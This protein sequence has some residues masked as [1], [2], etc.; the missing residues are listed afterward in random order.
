MTK[1]DNANQNLKRLRSFL[2]KTQREMAAIAGCSRHTIE[3]IEFGRLKLSPKLALKISRACA[4][5]FDWLTD[6]KA[7]DQIISDRGEPYNL[8]DFKS[9]QERDQT[10]AF[11]LAVEQMEVAVAYDLLC[12]VYQ[13]IG[14]NLQARAQFIR[15]LEDF[16]EKQVAKV[17]ELKIQIEK[18]NTE[19]N[20]RH[21]RIRKPAYLF[22][23]NSQQ[24][25][26]A[27]KR[28]NE[29]L[30]SMVDWERRVERVSD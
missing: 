11:Y 6:S 3:S 22:P 25:K 30:A 24:F 9:A 28:L 2:G 26:R 18:E 16:V 29:A 10:L 21:K 20:E 13:E 12:R 5:D 15:D 27:R 23:S 8:D 7:D 14:I 4:V 1:N 19:R 17:R